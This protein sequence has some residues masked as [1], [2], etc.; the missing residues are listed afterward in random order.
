M[1]GPKAQDWTVREFDG[2]SSL[3]RHFDDIE[4]RG[5]SIEFRRFR[6]N[7]EATLE[8]L[9]DVW[10]LDPINGPIPIHSIV[11]RE[12]FL[13]R[14]ITCMEV[15]LSE[16][17]KHI[18]K[19]KQ[20]QHVD[21]Q[22]LSN[23]LRNYFSEQH[24]KELLN[25]DPA[26][27][28]YSL[29]P[30]RLKFQ[31]KSNIK[32]FFKVFDIGFPQVLSIGDSWAKIIGKKPDSYMSMRHL[33]IHNGGVITT[34]FEP[35]D[36]AY[37]TNAIQDIVCL[38]KAVEKHLTQIPLLNSFIGRSNSANAEQGTAPNGNSAALHCRR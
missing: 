30:K 12:A 13:A 32:D 25:S 26:D 15:Y 29:L 23:C 10:D 2:R 14:L 4:T 18:S 7:F 33:L 36:N 5:V 17:A 37:L 27:T 9:S 6:L 16:V 34:M 19:K 11:Y 8:L 3:I 22:K 1:T 38:V 21:E 20:I 31:Q 24:V 35:I 28:I